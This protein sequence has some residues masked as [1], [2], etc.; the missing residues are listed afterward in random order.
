MF[1]TGFSSSEEE[2]SE[3]EELSEDER[4]ELS[5]ETELWDK[6]LVSGLEEEE[7][8]EEEELLSALLSEEVSEEVSLCEDSVTDELPLLLGVISIVSEL[9]SEEGFPKTAS[10]S[11]T[12]GSSETEQPETE[13]TIKTASKMQIIF[14]IL[15]P[16]FLNIIKNYN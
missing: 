2:L 12:S 10:F 6:L 15:F 11:I 14:F 7:E 9:L 1:S 16:P 8:E 4:D 5:E 13:T 3:A